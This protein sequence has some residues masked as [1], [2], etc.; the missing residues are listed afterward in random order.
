VGP[1]GTATVAGWSIDPDTASADQVAVYVDGVGL[2]WFNAALDR[3]DLAGPFPGYGT[4]HGYA[5]SFPATGGTHTVCTYGI[6]ISHGSNSTL[7]CRT[8]TVPT[9][10]P[11]GSL[12]AAWSTTGQ[13]GV[14][15][16][17]IDPDTAGV[18]QV[19]VYVDGAGLGWFPAGGPRPDVAAAF[20]L[21]GPSHGYHLTFSAGSGAHTVCTYGI[22]TGPGGNTTFGCRTVSVP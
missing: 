18:S 12:D 13:L 17:A 21:Y 14:A 3:P 7:G 20:P 11:V 16:W 5:V 4:G 8:F 15:G 9:G 19:A 22:N 10:A 6:N 1:I 2:G